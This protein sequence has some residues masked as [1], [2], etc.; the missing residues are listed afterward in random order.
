LEFVVSFEVCSAG[1][2]SV[3]KR[4]CL[5]KSPELGPELCAVHGDDGEEDRGKDGDENAAREEIEV[6]GGVGIAILVIS[7]EEAT[8]EEGG[9]HA[10]DQDDQAQTEGKVAG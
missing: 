3:C 8:G 1:A 5:R 4:S 9:S 6:A 7:V 2:S 10:Y